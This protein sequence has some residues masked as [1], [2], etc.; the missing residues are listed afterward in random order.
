[1]N[2]GWR[3]NSEHVDRLT[4]GSTNTVST[5]L[6]PFQTDRHP[7]SM[8]SFEGWKVLILRVPQGALVICGYLHLN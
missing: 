5:N 4:P 7:R 2:V 1:M 8:S 3:I 6:N